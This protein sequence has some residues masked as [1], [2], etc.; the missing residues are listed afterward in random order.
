MRRQQWVAQVASHAAANL[1]ASTA[2]EVIR[3]YEEL[4]EADQDR[5]DWAISE[6][7]RRLHQM[8]ERE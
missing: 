6:V 7:I 2:D 1:H 3:E 4:S 5:V 8:G